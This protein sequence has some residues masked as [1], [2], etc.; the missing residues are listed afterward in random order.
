GDV[1][2]FGGQIAD[3]LDCA[4]REHIVHRDLKPSN[5]MLTRSGAKLLDFGL[6]RAP[7]VESKG[8]L[9]TAS[10]DHRR[11]T[12]EGTIIGTVQYM[13]PEQLE[14]KEADARTDIFAFG[15]VLYEMLTG[16]KAFQGK[17]KTLLM[18]A[19]LTSE[20]KPVGHVEPM[21]P[22]WRVHLWRRGFCEA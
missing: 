12:A 14:G 17:S 9:S 7:L 5:V 2:R 6:R 19:I 16:K 13:A 20:P 18:S 15:V 10:F 21:R 3:A 4:H 1:L 8:L 11:A 22:G